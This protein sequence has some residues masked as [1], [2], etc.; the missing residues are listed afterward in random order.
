M[1][2][3][4]VNFAT[5]NIEYNYQ[6]KSIMKK[7]FLIIPAL[8]LLASCGG[9]QNQTNGSATD[10]TVATDTTNTAANTPTETASKPAYKDD[11][12]VAMQVWDI[13]LKSY[14]PF[15]TLEGDEQPTPKMIA[16]NR[17]YIKEESPRLAV[18]DSDSETEGFVETVACYMHDDGYWIVLDYWTS[19]DS[20][21]RNLTVYNYQDGK[22]TRIDDYFP[23]DFLSNGKYIGTLKEDEIG[24]VRDTDEEEECF[25]YKW[26]G[27]KFV[28]Q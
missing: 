5:D 28:K 11:G 8:A 20:P 21:D 13:L 10:T 25:W 18:F 9:N 16:K 12:H 7:S 2:K 15:G 14:D 17:K 6:Q 4:I 26:N 23:A 22:L 1:Q 27:K 24:V 3:K 19:T